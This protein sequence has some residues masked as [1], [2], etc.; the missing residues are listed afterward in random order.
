[1]IIDLHILDRVIGGERLLIHATTGQVVMGDI[2][3][4]GASGDGPAEIILWDG[5]AVHGTNP[6][7]Q[8]IFGG[9]IE[10]KGSKI[11][12]CSEYEKPS[13]CEYFIATPTLSG[14]SFIINVEQELNG[15]IDY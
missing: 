11:K 13:D 7:V 10:V 8:S 4:D 12:F 9:P 5:V 3:L 6:E 15:R 2:R 1:M 14:N